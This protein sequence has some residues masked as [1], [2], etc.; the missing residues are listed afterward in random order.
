[1]RVVFDLSHSSFA[2]SLVLD[3]AISRLAYLFVRSLNHLLNINC[4]A[5]TSL[6]TSLS[7]ST[8]IYSDYLL[9]LVP[10]SPLKSLTSTSIRPSPSINPLK[11]TLNQYSFIYSDYFLLLHLQSILYL[12]ITSIMLTQNFHE[13][14]HELGNDNPTISSIPIRSPIYIPIDISMRACN[15]ESRSQSRCTPSTS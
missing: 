3:I 13:F 11:L 10:K 4:N 5:S 12:Q 9:V 15:S 6:Q 2:S 8:F 14:I 1:V 7:P